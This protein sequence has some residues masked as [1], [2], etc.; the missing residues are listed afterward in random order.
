MKDPKKELKKLQRERNKRLIG[1][2]IK[3]SAHK[4]DLPH[5][6]PITPVEKRKYEVQK[7]LHLCNCKMDDCSY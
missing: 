2:K 5:P 1:I 7:Q 4:N 6:C 3:R